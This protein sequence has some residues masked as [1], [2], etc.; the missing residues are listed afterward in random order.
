MAVGEIFDAVPVAVDNNAT[1]NIQPAGT[2]E[3]VIHNIYTGSGSCELYKYDGTTLS[4]IDTASGWLG[5][6]FH[7]RNAC[8]L[9]VKNIS[10]GSL[11]ISFDGIYTKA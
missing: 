8:Y 2:A 11:N 6:A 9:Q 4:K 5:Y 7:A 1:L 10:G 3:A